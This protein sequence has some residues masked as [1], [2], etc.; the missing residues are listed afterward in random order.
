MKQNKI[1][2]IEMEIALAD[3]FNFKQHLIVPG[4]K[5]GFYIPRFGEL[6]EC[7]LLICT[8]SGCLWECEIKI[9][10]ADLIKD[11]KKVHGHHHEAIS[12]LYFAIPTYLEPFIKH[13]PERAGI[14]LVDK[15]YEMN[16]KEIRKPVWKKKG[17]RA[18]DKDRLK[19]AMLGAMRIWTLKKNLVKK[20]MSLF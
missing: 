20:Q 17:Y 2:T 1:K 3:H 6:H 15:E 11:A 14:I 4:V 7:D 10:K 9:T 13:I 8:K 19:I 16:C 12:R 5:Y 18:T